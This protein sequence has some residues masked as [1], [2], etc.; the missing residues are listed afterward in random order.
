[1]MD[2]IYLSGSESVETAGRRISEA[3][4]QMKEAARIIDQV[5]YTQ[6]VFM[7]QWLGTLEKILTESIPR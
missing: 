3:A 6:R 5:L 2:H 7:D 1:M 4:E